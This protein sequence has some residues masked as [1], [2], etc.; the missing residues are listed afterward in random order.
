MNRISICMLLALVGAAS[1]LAGCAGELEGDEAQLSDEA[2]S[3]EGEA[4]PDLDLAPGPP[5][6]SARFVGC[7][8]GKPSFTIGWTDVI[9]AAAPLR[10]EVQALAGT[11]ESSWEVIYRGE[12][13]A[14]RYEGSDGRHDFV[15]VRAC[16]ESGCSSY[17]Q[18]VAQADCT[19]AAR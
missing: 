11:G 9:T 13:T 1:S 16:N 2:L 14:A 15:R 19:P 4:A 12:R 6:V 7:R 18:V 8:A 3:L 10:H 5:V 17:S